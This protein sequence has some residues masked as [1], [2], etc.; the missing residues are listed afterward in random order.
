MDEPFS[1]LDTITSEAL[2]DDLLKIWRSYAMTILMVNHLIPDAIELSDQILIMGAHPG[3]IEKTI[4]V[5]LPRPRDTRGEQFF[6]QVDQL[7]EEV[8]TVS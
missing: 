4:A 6:K 2:K 7:T 8:R 3:H 1:N 5:D